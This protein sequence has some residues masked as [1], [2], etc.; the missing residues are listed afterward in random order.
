L[1]C[2]KLHRFS[3]KTTPV[4]FVQQIVTVY[5]Y[6]EYNKIRVA[7]LWMHSKYPVI[8]PNFIWKSLNEQVIGLWMLITI[9]HTSQICTVTWPTCRDR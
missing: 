2:F 3:Q 4:N 1:L 5:L 8:L 7:G 9:D 6:I